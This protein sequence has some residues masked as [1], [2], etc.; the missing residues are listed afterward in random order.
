VD[1]VSVVVVDI[2]TDD[3]STS[4]SWCRALIWGPFLFFSL[5]IAWILKWDALSDE[6]MG[7]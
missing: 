6:R 1:S 4:L 7:L 2:L 5:T 3:H